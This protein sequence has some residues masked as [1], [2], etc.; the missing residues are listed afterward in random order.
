MKRA[1]NSEVGRRTAQAKYKRLKNK[2]QQITTA[3]STP[4]VPKQK[5]LKA[6]TSA[7]MHTTS[8]RPATATSKTNTKTT[9]A[10]ITLAPSVPKMVVKTESVTTTTTKN[11]KATTS[12]TGP[13]TKAKAKKQ[14]EVQLLETI[15]E[16]LLSESDDDEYSLLEDLQTALADDDS[17]DHEVDNELPH[18]DEEIEGKWPTMGYKPETYFTSVEKDDVPLWKHIKGYV[19]VVSV[20]TTTD[21]SV[22]IQ[23]GNSKCN[24]LIDTGATKSV[25]S[26]SY[27]R[28]L[29]LPSTKQVYNIDV[30]SASGNKLKTIGITECTFSLG[31]QPYT[32][33]FL[34]C[35][36]LSRPI[37][38]G[39]DFLRAN[40][41]G[42][43]WSDNGKFVLQQKNSVLVES[44]E[45][46]ITRPRIY[47]NN[48]ID[49]MFMFMATRL[50]DNCTTST[51]VH[52]R[53]LFSSLQIQQFNQ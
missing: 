34:V 39:L 1:I 19:T 53:V 48:H 47:T 37:I 2:V 12:Y 44:I 6:T 3:S 9:K 20:G 36:D 7:N 21:A 11:S 30:R 41:I 32:Y 16:N 35:K 18:S 13:I 15:S 17:E 8:A 28:D 38:L 24:A 14:A 42:T 5:E 52:N 40:R 23:V 50:T 45:T 43:D 51:T 46:Y 26:E 4:P 31:N 33:N 10:T 29:M 49:I 25:I 22:P 27:Y